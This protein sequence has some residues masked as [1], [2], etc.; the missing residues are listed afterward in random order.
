MHMFMI[1]KFEWYGTVWRNLNL[2]D[3]NGNLPHKNIY[4]MWLSHAYPVISSILFADELSQFLFNCDDESTVSLSVVCDH[5]LD[6]WNGQDE[7]WCGKLIT[8]TSRERQG[9]SNH[10]QLHC[11]Y[12]R[13]FRPTT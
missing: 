1:Y 10:R 12:Q 7:Q 2:V 9:V 3:T 6:C 13:L 5:K 8:A 4:D 11:L